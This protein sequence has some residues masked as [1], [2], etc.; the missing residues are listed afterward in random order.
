[1][2]KKINIWICDSEMNASPKISTKMRDVSSGKK[3]V[4]KSTM[5]HSYINHSPLNSS[6]S[7][8]PRM[9]SLMVF[10]NIPCTFF[11]SEDRRDKYP[12]PM[13]DH[14]LFLIRCFS[15][16]WSTYWP[17]LF[18]QRDTFPATCMASKGTTTLH[19]THTRL[20]NWALCTGWRHV[21]NSM[22]THSLQI[23]SEH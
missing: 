22:E 15:T 2:K 11:T 12:R 5:G 3:K 21:T 20:P 1:M 14:H 4:K 7:P 9:M 10:S 13:W 23:C 16:F 18:P 8:K 6:L 17:Q 19:S